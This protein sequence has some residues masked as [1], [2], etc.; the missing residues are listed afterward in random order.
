LECFQQILCGV[1]DLGWNDE[2]TNAVVSKILS[3]RRS[4][5]VLAKALPIDSE[6]IFER[7][8]ASKIKGGFD[9]DIIIGMANII[10]NRE[11]VNVAEDDE[12]ERRFYSRF[13]MTKRKNILRDDIID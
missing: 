13:R 4:I 3:I 11:D 12:K 5:S 9:P 10:T 2:T 6:I 8:M 7:E 1:S